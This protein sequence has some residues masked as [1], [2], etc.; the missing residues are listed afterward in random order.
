MRKILLKER[1]HDNFSDLLVKSMDSEDA[2]NLKLTMV[3]VLKNLS[4]VKPSYL[5]CHENEDSTLQ[6]TFK[7]TETLAFSHLTYLHVLCVVTAIL[8]SA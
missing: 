8:Q 2:F 4:F 5:F 3:S 6:N 7:K 1:L